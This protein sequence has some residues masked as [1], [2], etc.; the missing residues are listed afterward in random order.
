MAISAIFFNVSLSYTAP[1]GLPGVLTT[2]K[3]VLSVMYSSRS[4]GLKSLWVS[5]G[6]HTVSAP[7]NL[8]AELYE[9]HAGSKRIA[10]SP[11]SSTVIIISKIACFAPGVTSTSEPFASSPFSVLS[12]SAIASLSCGIPADGA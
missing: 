3:R 5:V 8:I 12:F 4:S 7:A 11:S 9:T 10:S 2:I 1:V 6:T